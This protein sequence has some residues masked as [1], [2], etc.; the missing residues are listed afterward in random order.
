VYIYHYDTSESVQNVGIHARI[1]THSHNLSSKY[2][3]LKMNND[4]VYLIY[5]GECPI[6]S[7]AAKVIKLRQAVG[8]LE[9][10]NARDQHSLVEEINNHKYDLNK[11]ILVKYQESLYFG[12][13]AMHL[14]ALLGS[15]VDLFNKIN[16]T[17][18]KSKILLAICYPVFKFI[19]SCLLKILDVKKI[20]NSDNSPIFKSVFGESW[21][22]LPLILKKHYSIRPYT[23]DSIKLE[24]LMD[25]KH[26]KFIGLIQPLLKV[27]GALVPYEGSNIATTIYSKSDSNNDS[28]I[29]ERHFKISEKKTFIYRSTFLR[30]KDNE[31]IEMMKFGLGWVS[32][33]SYKNKK[34]I[35]T[36]KGYSWRIFGLIVPIPLTF[37]FGKVYAEEKE[38]DDNQF[39]MKMKITHPLFGEI[40][41]YSGIF[42]II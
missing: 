30:L 34:I 39:R 13:D 41:K 10:I 36:H 24:G 38:V 15:P 32:Y 1:K 29:F 19:R 31:V 22:A 4:V 26:S 33:Y 11:G 16:V 40:F 3:N 18:F 35:L 7:Y 12:N 17:L 23:N 8:K 14:L 5:D 20:K 21:D 25:I 9:I 37:I 2:S 42:K 6:C 28:F 27:F